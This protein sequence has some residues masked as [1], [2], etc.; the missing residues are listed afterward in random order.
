VGVRQKES[1]GAAPRDQ[2]ATLEGA[3]RFCYAGAVPRIAVITTSYPSDADD[4]A[5][6]FVRAEVLRLAAD[7]H[8]VTVIAPRA[9][10][11]ETNLGVRV[12]GLPHFGAFGAP[13]ALWRLRARPDRWVGILLFVMTTRGA[14]RRLG[15]F[16]RTCAHFMLPSFWPIGARMAGELEVVIHGSDLRLFERL[17]R[18][19]RKRVLRTKP[20]VNRSFRC[21]SHELARRLAALFDADA[22]PLIR[23]EPSPI[24]VPALPS[25]AELRETLGVGP[26]PL[27]VIVSRLIASKRVAVALR[28]ASSASG[29]RVIVCG[30]G[31]E[32]ACLER[33]F[34]E[35]HFCGQVPRSRALEWMAASDV[36]LSASLEEGAPSVVREA[37]ALGVP[38]VTTE[39]ADL[40]QWAARDSGIFVAKQRVNRNQQQ[41]Q[42]QQQVLAPTQA[43]IQYLL[44]A[45]VLPG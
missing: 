4:G 5:G 7:G 10:R 8:A 2:R 24:D 3:P 21:V 19:L 32:R 41:Q 43:L 36:V 9:E 11:S 44:Q 33:E 30:D 29:A 18:W 45:L 27:I 17:P 38:V 23:V 26:E 6:H 12:L 31:P 28:A 13:G 20:G 16:D 22:C 37:R 40:S 35:A 39:A 14:L 1:R 25:R 34:P 42:P 15:P